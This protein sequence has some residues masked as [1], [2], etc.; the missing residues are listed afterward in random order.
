M[1]NQCNVSCHFGK[2]LSLI[3]HEER[4]VIVASEADEEMGP[5][6]APAPLAPNKIL[7]SYTRRNL[8]RV[9]PR[10]TRL[11]SSN[12]DPLPFWRSGC[13][14]VALNYQAKDRPL[15]L[16]RALFRQNGRCGYVLK[17]RGLCG[18]SFG[19]A[20]SLHRIEATYHFSGPN[21]AT[22]PPT[23][24]SKALSVR[25]ISGQHL[26]KSEEQ[27]MRGGVIEP[28]VKLRIIGH[29]CDEAECVTKV[30]PKVGGVCTERGCSGGDK[31]QSWHL[32]VLSE[33]F[34]PFVERDLR[35]RDPSARVLLRRVPR[36]DALVAGRRPPRLLRRPLLPP[37][38]RV[39]ER[40]PGEL[41]RRAAHPRLPLCPRHDRGRARGR[42]RSRARAGPLVD[43]RNSL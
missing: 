42:R 36:E 1:S 34:Q 30:V 5:R 32:P 2:A 10:G 26:P 43:G 7:R 14:M 11:L 15:L 6:T 28:Y 39:Q 20:P 3:Q 33:R 31:K 13:Q 12:M 35:V 27:T 4:D 40:A 22:D 38:Q 9:Y 18:E 19:D 8:I 16:N 23:S 21:A 29:L 17:P 25:I 41:R 24:G 37:P